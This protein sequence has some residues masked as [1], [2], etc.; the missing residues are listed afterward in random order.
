MPAARCHTRQASSSC[1]GV[2][3]PSRQDPQGR[4][5]RDR[6]IEQPTTFEPWINPK[7]AKLLGL[8]IPHSLQ[9]QA[10]LTEP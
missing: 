9:P 6:P 2:L 1:S 8:T 5:P 10:T 4:K 3:R 7:T